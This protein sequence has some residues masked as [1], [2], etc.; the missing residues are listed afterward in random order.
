MSKHLAGSPCA[1]TIPHPCHAPFA[2]ATAVSCRACGVRPSGRAARPVSGLP[3]AQ[4]ACANPIACENQ[5]PGTPQSTWDVS[6]YS[7]TIQGFADPFSVNIG[8]SINFKISR[9][10]PATRSTFTAWA[11]TAG[12][13]RA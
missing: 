7:T 5:L 8:Q 10:R 13:A 1:Q 3:P 12:T 2:R 4:A 9:R 6:S 11:I